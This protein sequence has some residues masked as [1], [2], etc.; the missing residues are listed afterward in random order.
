MQQ[1]SA[2]KFSYVFYLEWRIDLL[3]YLYCGKSFLVV[4]TRHS[5]D[6]TCG[7]PFALISES[8]AFRSGLF[9]DLD[10]GMFLGAAKVHGFGIR[11]GCRRERRRHT[12]TAWFWMIA[13]ETLIGGRIGLTNRIDF[14]IRFKNINYFRCSVNESI[15]FLNFINIMSNKA[16]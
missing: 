10:I 3:I 16:W 1:H 12:T 11:C 2:A 14:K 6:A 4:S 9:R 7:P 13:L 8:K 5:W 15:I